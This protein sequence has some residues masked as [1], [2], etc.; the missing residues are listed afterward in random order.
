MNTLPA[1]IRRYVAS[2][3]KQILVV[4]H[5]GDGSHEMENTAAAFRRAAADPRVDGIEFDVQLTRDRVPVV[6]HDRDTIRL[7]PTE[8][9][10]VISD[11]D[12]ASLPSGVT[13]LDRALRTIRGCGRTIVLDIELKQYRDDADELRELLRRTQALVQRHGLTQRVLYTSFDAHRVPELPVYQICEGRQHSERGPV[14]QDLTSRHGR[15]FAHYIH[16][17]SRRSVDGRGSCAA[18]A[19]QWNDGADVADHRLSRDACSGDV[20]RRHG[21][22]FFSFRMIK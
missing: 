1:A 14:V 13:T 9:G 20:G 16:A 19:R 5:R 8:T 15:A 3:G 12:A 2:T 22:F 11:T 18:P 10:R 7:F 17:G 21:L 4:S 6:F